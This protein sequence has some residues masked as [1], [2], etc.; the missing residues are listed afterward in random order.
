MMCCISIMP[1]TGA[2]M[3][4]EVQHAV[5]LDGVP[6]DAELIRFAEAALPPDYSKNSNSTVVVRTPKK[7]KKI[8]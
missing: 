7:K 5:S 8:L 3:S 4:V 6:P 1:K 2:P